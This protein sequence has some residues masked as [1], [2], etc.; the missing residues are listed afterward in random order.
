M[1]NTRL[2]TETI[3]T[4]NLSTAQGPVT[5]A[6]HRVVETEMLEY[7]SG[8]IIAGGVTNIVEPGGATVIFSDTFPF[9]LPNTQYIIVG[10]F[11]S[12]GPN[13][14]ADNDAV[15][16]ITSKTV[17]G[18]TGISYEWD[19]GYQQVAFNWLAISTPSFTY[20]AAY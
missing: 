4:S 11:L 12:T 8:K 1:A 5:A 14:N 6:R 18:F 15:W 19:G 3:I 10:H 9:T 13:W 2:Q 20:P 7:V 17:T 16:S